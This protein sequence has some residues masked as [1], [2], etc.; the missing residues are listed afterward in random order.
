MPE[1][2]DSGEV[3]FIHPPAAASFEV[4]LPE[5]AVTFS[6]RIALA[7]ESW[8]WGGD[9]V[10]FILRV[11]TADGQREELL[12]QYIE[13]VP[14]NQTW[15]DV[16]IPLTQYAGQTITLTLTTENGPAGSSTG[17]WAGWQTPRLL[18]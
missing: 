7:P 12:R 2:G 11:E 18:W 15:H 10:T 14:T 8:E 9:G 6:S 3:I 17:D 1:N 13:N 16:S 5:T 4:T